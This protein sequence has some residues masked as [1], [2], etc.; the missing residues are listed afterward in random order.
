MKNLYSKLAKTISLSKSN[1]SNIVSKWQYSL[2]KD[3][4]FYNNQTELLAIWLLLFLTITGLFILA[5]KSA[6]LIKFLLLILALII[7][8]L[9]F[10][11]TTHYLFAL[12]NNKEKKLLVKIHSLLN[13][14]F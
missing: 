5:I 13:K 6:I 8:F 11:A 7:L 3:F 10:S 1:F 14:S 4:S 9:G 12:K 2:K